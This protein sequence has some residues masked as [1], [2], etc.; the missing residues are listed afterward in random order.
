MAS[1]SAYPVHFDIRRPDHQSRITNF[2]LGIGMLIRVVLLI[3][4]L[5]ILYALQLLSS[6]LY[7]IACFAILFSGKFPEGMFN[8]M[9][10]V[11]R[12][13]ANVNGYMLGLYDDYPPFSTNTQ[14]GYPLTLDIDY[15]DS[16]SRILN[17]PFYIGMLIRIILLIPNLIVLCLFFIVM[18]LILIIAPFAI[19]FTGSFPAGMHSFATGVMR[20]G[21]RLAAYCYGLTDKYPPFG[22]S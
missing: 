7:F 18:Y 11:L 17:F 21:Q 19:L 14:A 3:P 4:H 13:G 20:W 12:W 8:M 15:P 2:P 16:A 6:L 1:E 22:T 5:L 9:L 10:G